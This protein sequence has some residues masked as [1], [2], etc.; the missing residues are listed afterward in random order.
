MKLYI[1]IKKVTFFVK[2]SLFSLTF[3]RFFNIILNG[4]FYLSNV[5]KPGKFYGGDSERKKI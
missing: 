5:I 1:F 4:T 3:I 2:K